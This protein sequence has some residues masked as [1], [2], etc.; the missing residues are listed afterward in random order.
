MFA[1]DW[2]HFYGESPGLWPSL[3]IFEFYKCFISVHAPAQFSHKI[4]TGSSL[5]SF[6]LIGISLIRRRH[7]DLR[8]RTSRRQGQ[9]PSSYEIEFEFS[10]QLQPWDQTSQRDNRSI[11][12]WKISSENDPPGQPENGKIGYKRLAKA[13]WFSQVEKSMG[14]SNSLHRRNVGAAF[15]TAVVISAET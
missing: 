11:P 6:K 4:L 10:P 3:S 9:Y 1:Q 2:R 8:T 13:N 14:R 7:R 15:R 5:N 12:T